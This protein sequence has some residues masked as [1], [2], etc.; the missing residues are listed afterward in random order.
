[1]N[2]HL[3]LRLR[4]PWVRVATC[5]CQHICFCGLSMFFC[6]QRLFNPF[7]P[8]FSQ[9]FF[10]C[11]VFVVEILSIFFGSCTS[12]EFSASFWFPCD[13]F[14]KRGDI[15]GSGNC[16]SMLKS[17]SATQIW[18]TKNWI[19]PTFI[20]VPRSVDFLVTTGGNGADHECCCIHRMRQAFNSSFFSGRYVRNIFSSLYVRRPLYT[21]DC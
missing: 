19:L 10:Y 9:S 3:N 2:I 6:C 18:P 15:A 13:A 12:S 20:N 21:C 1:M 14:S 4:K 11:W 16:K 17:T 7:F 8:P 5:F